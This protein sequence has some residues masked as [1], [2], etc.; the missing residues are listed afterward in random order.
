MLIAVDP[1]LDAGLDPH[2][3]MESMLLGFGLGL[4]ADLVLDNVRG[5][6]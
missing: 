4:G 1:E 5:I 2:K 3:G 6:N